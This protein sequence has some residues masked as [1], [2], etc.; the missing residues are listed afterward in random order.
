MQHWTWICNI[1]IVLHYGHGHAAEDI[2]TSSMDLDRS[3]DMDMQHRDGMQNE[4]GHAA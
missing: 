2:D 4:L 1:Y 3:I